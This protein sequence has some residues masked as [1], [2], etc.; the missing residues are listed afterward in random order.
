MISA[1]TA[2]PVRS[3]DVTSSSSTPPR[4]PRVV[5]FSPTRVE[6]SHPRADQLT[7]QRPPLLIAQVGYSDLQHCSP[8][9]ACQKPPTSEARMTHNLLVLS[10]IPSSITSYGEICAYF[11]KR[12]LRRWTGKIGSQPPTEF[13]TATVR[14]P[15]TSEC[16]ASHG[17]ETYFD[18]L[19]ADAY[20]S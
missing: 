9:T 4:V 2:S 14:G 11:G 17:L 12:I 1:R 8:L 5:R 19:D 10:T 13:A 20:G 3:I 7:L 6:L 16:P 18:Q 15:Y